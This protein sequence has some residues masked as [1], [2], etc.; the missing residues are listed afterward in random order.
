MSSPETDGAESVSRTNGKARGDKI[1]YARV[2]LDI[3]A[4]VGSLATPPPHSAG[5][6]AFFVVALPDKSTGHPG[7]FAGYTGAAESPTSALLINHGLHIGDPD[8]SESQVGTTDRADIM[9]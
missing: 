5:W 1:A 6:P 2:P 7:Q 8:R 3:P 9:I 4:I